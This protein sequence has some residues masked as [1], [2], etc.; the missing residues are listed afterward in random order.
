MTDITTLD[1]TPEE[2]RTGRITPVHLSAA[3]RALRDDGIVVLNDIVSMDH[4]AA[5]REK[6]L[7]DLPAYLART[8]APFNFN[9]GNVQ[10]E[11]PPFAPYLYKDVLLNDIVISVTHSLL[12]DGLHNGFYSGN[13]AVGGSGQRQ[14]V[15]ADVGQLWPN[16]EVA[17]PPFGLVVNV[18][19]VDMSAENGSTE[20]WPGTHRDTTIYVQHGDIKLPPAAVEARRAVRPPLQPTVRAGGVVIRDL[21][22]WHAGMPNRT[23]RARPMIAMIHWVSWWPAQPVP[24]PRREEAF[25]QHPIL[26][27][28][29]EWVD[30]PINYIAHG[31]AYDLQAS[32]AS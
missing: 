12:G 2:V 17:T 30:G 1:I 15:H 29:A 10:Q 16:L 27:T 5:L 31:G 20:V 28:D 11:P 32:T 3:T 14:P 9:T 21:R 25:F 7:Y 13:T 6:M 18:P 19:V 22:L 24:F 23:D 4:I 26:K 8:D